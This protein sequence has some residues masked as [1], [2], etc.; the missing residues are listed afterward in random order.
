MHR[1]T[2][3]FLSKSMD[4]KIKYVSFTE[5]YGTSNISNIKTKYKKSTPSVMAQ[6]SERRPVFFWCQLWSQ[7]M[8]PK[9]PVL[10]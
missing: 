8:K 10:F 5:N 2:G 4:Q 6:M 3:Y 1:K 7:S 9:C